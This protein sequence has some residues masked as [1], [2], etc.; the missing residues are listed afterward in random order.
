[1][2]LQAFFNN[3]PQLI[4]SS[5]AISAL[6]ELILELAI[7]GRLA[8][9]DPRDEPAS[10]LL[11]R[12]KDTNSLKNRLR[13][14]GS[15]TLVAETSVP[16]SIPGNWEWTFLSQVGHEWGQKRP[17]VDFTYIDVAAID[18]QR[19]VI[20]DEVNVLKPNQAPSR[21]R[22]IVK[23]GTL[24]Y[25]TVR[26]YLLNIAIVEKEYSP[27]PIAS[28]A[29]AIIHPFAGISEKYLFYYLRSRTFIDFVKTQMQGVAYPAI[30]DEKLFGALVPLPPTR[31]QER[32][33]TKVDELMRLCDDLEAKQHTKR[34]SRVRLNNSAL[35]SLNDAASFG[36]QEFEGAA[37]RLAE[38]F[39]KLYDSLETVGKLRSTILQLAVRGKLVSQDPQ[40]E[41]AAIV[42]SMIRKKRKSLTDGKKS[43]DCSAQL[44]ESP[45][46]TPTGWQWVPLAELGIFLGGGTPSKSNPA[47]WKGNIPWVSPK[48]MKKLYIDRAEDHISE[49]ALQE[50]AVRKIPAGSLLMVVRGMILAHSFPVALTSVEVTINQDM[51]ALVFALPELSDYVLLACRGLKDLM[52]NK[53]ARSTHGTCRLETSVIESFLIPVPPFSEQKRILAKVNQ[54]M[55]L[56]DDLEAKLRENEA[57][58]EKLMNAAVQYVLQTV[59]S[60][61]QVN[62]AVQSSTW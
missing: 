5:N 16:F 24:L 44:I 27:E 55:A 30:N 26:P 19:G 48:D 15:R 7:K 12:V 1:M 51:K 41:S 21:A 33:V 54:L 36:S 59:S 62:D 47:F 35:A 28:T 46:R 56:C 40:D 57:H 60:A 14:T 32:I 10:V 20:M 50:T 18:N 9:Q 22:K 58:S 23:R 43:Q 2:R 8:A 29:F 6:R 39:D 52:L 45:F 25:S 31:E 49:Q 34:E 61:A 17:D 53:V 3:F 4:N 37:A 38:H 13:E 11:E 42:S